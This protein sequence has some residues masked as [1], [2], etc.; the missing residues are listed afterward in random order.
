MI[1]IYRYIFLCSWSSQTYVVWVEE[2]ISFCY[3]TTVQPK[4]KLVFNTNKKSIWSI[5]VVPSLVVLDCF[6]ISIHLLN[7]LICM[8]RT[9]RGS[10]VDGSSFTHEH[11]VMY[12]KGLASAQHY[13]W[14]AASTRGY[15]SQWLGAVE[16]RLATQ[17]PRP[18]KSR[19]NNTETWA[20][21]GSGGRIVT[22]TRVDRR[23]QLDRVTTPYCSL[24]SQRSIH[25]CLQAMELNMFGHRVTN[26]NNDIYLLLYKYLPFFQ[27]DVFV[28]WYNYRYR[29]DLS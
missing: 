17:L 24:H 19:W 13:F 27:S 22:A 1:H 29:N 5:L 26:K 11:I 10:T 2:A 25:I 21:A 23:P 7:G 4:D 18:D 28:Y 9:W 6:D 3:K 20:G 8:D 14:T 16:L 12:L 15:V